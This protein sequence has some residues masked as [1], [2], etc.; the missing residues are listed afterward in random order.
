MKRKLNLALPVAALAV[1]SLV[2]PSGLWA[3]PTCSN[4]TLKGTYSATITGTLGTSPFA[5]LDLVTST[6]KGTFSGTGTL[7]TDGVISTVSFTATYTVNSNCTGSAALSTGVTQNFNIKSDGSEVMFI[8]TNNGAT[9]TGTAKQ[10]YPEPGE[11]SSSSPC[12]PPPVTATSAAQE[13]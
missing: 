4:A 12:I 9:I 11:C 2:M 6:G 8:A 10:I 5:E 3:A 7:S 13:P 1:L